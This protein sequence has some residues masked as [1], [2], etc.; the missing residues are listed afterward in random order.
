MSAKC[1]ADANREEVDAARTC[2]AAHAQARAKRN[3][4]TLSELP[5]TPLTSS[6]TSHTH[7]HSHT[8]R[9]QN[10]YIHSRTVRPLRVV[11]I[12]FAHDWLRI[13][14]V[15]RCPDPSPARW[16]V[17]NT[18]WV[19]MLFDFATNIQYNTIR[20]HFVS[21]SIYQSSLLSPWNIFAAHCHSIFMELGT[22]PRA[23]YG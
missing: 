2:S 23:G 1:V 20:L 4:L 18:F 8:E 16:N 17:G 21:V 22:W 7:T 13:R 15:R 10:T 6:T 19:A 5:A 11:E 9:N 3:C 14:P 12:E